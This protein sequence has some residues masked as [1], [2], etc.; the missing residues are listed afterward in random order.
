MKK[1]F[2][3]EVKIGLCVLVAI[4]IL[5][6][7]IDYLKG[8]NVF[9]ASNYYYATYHNVEG[10]AQSAPVTLNGFKVGVVRS[11]NYDYEHPGN[12][13]VELSLDKELKL[14]EGTKAMLTTDLLGTASISLDL[15]D[16]T[17][18]H[19]VGDKLE[20]GSKAGLMDAIGGDMLPKIGQIF[21]KVDTLLTCV[22]ALVSDPSLKKA[23]GDID[24]ITSDLRRTAAE[25]ARLTTG[26]A[27][28]PSQ[29]NPILT[30]VKSITGNVSDI[31]TDVSQLSAQLRDMPIDSLV[32]DLQ[33]TTDNLRLMTEQLNNPDSSLGKIMND[34]S[35]Y[36]NLNNAANSLD[37]LL[38]DV[39]KNP[40]RYI[41]IKVF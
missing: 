37:S 22:N 40:K 11:I 30:D 33:A 34:P 9:K 15:G 2:T 24:D 29:L 17:T 13:N 25:V 16:G 10:L 19:N 38:V 21:T 6:Y 18:Y 14:P 4:V 20:S 3:K 39:K 8:I 28:L 7:G 27:T 32:N 31:T 23:V 41:S 26:L 35:L 1:I 5:I 12:V 36:N